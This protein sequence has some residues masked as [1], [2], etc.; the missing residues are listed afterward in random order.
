VI[1]VVAPETE[2]IAALV[3]GRLREAGREFR[4]LDAESESAEPW[5]NVEW[6]RGAIHGG[7]FAGPGWRVDI[8]SLTG[9][10]IRLGAQSAQPDVAMAT[11]RDAVRRRIA[12]A[13]RVGLLYTV[14]DALPCTVVNKL[15]GGISN[16]SKAHQA[17]IIRNCGLAVPETLITNDPAAARAFMAAHR[18]A[19]IAKSLSG[20]RSIVKQ[21]GPS[22]RARLP[23]L[24]HGPAQFQALV[25]GTNI[26]V[27]V[28]G[29]RV[30]ATRIESEAVD[31]RYASQDGIPVGMQQTILPDDIAI[32]CVRLTQ[33]LDLVLAGIDL[34]RTPN[35]EYVCFEANPAP[36]FIAY[37]AVTRQPIS[38]A[39][40]SIL[41]RRP[42]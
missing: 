13:E 33:R 8:D 4:V 5:L 32:A 6:R 42:S 35:G 3:M 22:H 21:I 39:V 41:A 16:M 17:L 20:V 14:L 7:W 24:R 25:P 26:R 31:Y 18:G 15:L 12:R 9:V 40:A 28:V 10:F 38:T 23:L 11:E 27:H 37:E 36:A 19:V 29:E 1:L 30:F 34:K 2:P